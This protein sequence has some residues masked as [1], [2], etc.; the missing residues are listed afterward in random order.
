M[1]FTTKEKEMVEAY[2]KLALQEGFANLTL[3]KIAAAAEISY[4]K[5]HYY[6]GGDREILLQGIVE[7]VAKEA[8][9]FALDYLKDKLSLGSPLT[10]YIDATFAWAKAKPHHASF[11]LYYYYLCTIKGHLRRYNP[12]FLT[13]ARERIIGLLR[14]ERPNFLA[15]EIQTIATSVHSALVGNLI[16]AHTD[17]KAGASEMYRSLTHRTVR[18]LIYAS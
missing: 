13:A 4:G 1:N 6:F 8:Q 2:L 12:K 5:A 9:I 17:N 7:L 14:L 11:W 15:G 18:G 3:Q 16:L 10:R